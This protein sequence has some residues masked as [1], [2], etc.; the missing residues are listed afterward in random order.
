MNIYLVNITIDICKKTFFL[1]SDD[2]SKKKVK[3]D[4]TK[5]FMDVLDLVLKRADPEIVEY[6]DPLVKED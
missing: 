1:L 5:Q 4:T 2:G 3:C 6:A